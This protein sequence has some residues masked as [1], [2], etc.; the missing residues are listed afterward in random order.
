MTIAIKDHP[1]FGQTL[2]RV[3]GLFD[4]AVNGG[5]CLTVNYNDGLSAGATQVDAP[6]QDFVV[7]DDVVLVVRDAKVTKIDLTDATEMQVAQG[8]IV[9]DQDGRRQATLLIP[10]G[11]HASESCRWQ[12]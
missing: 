10:A 7:V 9:S 6:W 11:T 12:H 4:L 3:D 2:S 8:S 1:E 5:G